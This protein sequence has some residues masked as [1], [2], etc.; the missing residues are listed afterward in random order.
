MSVRERS[1]SSIG[2]A[3][4]T[5]DADF[6]PEW[7]WEGPEMGRCG[8]WHVNG[9]PD[10][11][12]EDLHGAILDQINTQLG[13]QD[14]ACQR[15]EWVRNHHDNR[16]QFVRHSYDP[17]LP[18]HDYW[19]VLVYTVRQRLVQADCG[20][21]QSKPVFD[22]MEQ[23]FWQSTRGIQLRTGVDNTL[24]FQFTLN[25]Q[26]LGRF[27][28]GEGAEV[29]ARDPMA[30]VLP[31]FEYRLYDRQPDDGGDYRQTVGSMAFAFMAM[32]A[33]KLAGTSIDGHPI[34][35]VQVPCRHAI[36]HGS[37]LMLSPRLE[38]STAEGASL[39]MP[40]IPTQNA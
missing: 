36:E 32:L 11:A 3:N 29:G 34:F 17:W 4:Y 7:P 28:Y 15:P 40:S 27:A 23:R 30:Y 8:D 10:T 35:E 6:E 22:E 19:E 38:Y 14:F 9:L 25:P 12:T 18:F 16:E 26:Y 2:P 31:A 37:W 39:T 24:I 1:P 21:I 33:N 20:W 5:R 13:D